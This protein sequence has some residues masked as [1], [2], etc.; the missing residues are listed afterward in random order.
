LTVVDVTSVLG[1]SFYI[2]S[3]K[4]RGNAVAVT[5]TKVLTALHGDV[6][7]GAEV[8]LTDSKGKV[9]NARVIFSQYQQSIVDIAVV[10]LCYGEEEFPVVIPICAHKVSLLQPI[11][12]VA[13]KSGLTDTGSS[14]YAAH[15]EV[16]FIEPE[17]PL[18]QSQYSCNRGFSGA[19]VIIAVEGGVFHV[20]G[21]HVGTADDTESPPPIK[22]RK[23]NV[24]SADSVSAS[25]NSLAHS[26]H[27][28]TA[29]S[30]I[31][32]AIR[33]PDVKALLSP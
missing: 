3:G 4:Y 32:E 12:V 1:A 33:V 6:D 23:G 2:S 22:K 28:H 7:I 11:I 17:S 24:P 27:G 20:V 19:G 5:S 25:S 8:K 10:A 14:A 15:G 30:L 26:I 9:R 13:M 31:C 21:V 16:T 29:F 18:F